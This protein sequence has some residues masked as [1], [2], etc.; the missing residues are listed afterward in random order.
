MSDSSTTL[1]HVLDDPPPFHQKLLEY[2]ARP[3]WSPDGRRIAFVDKSFGDVSE[4]D[5]ETRKVRELTKGLGDHHSFLRVLFLPNGD[6]LLIGPKVFK[7]Y[8][9]S[10]YRES[11]LWIMD[12]DAQFAPRP[13]GLRPFEG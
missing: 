13:L 8:E 12:R 4:I 6:Y 7:D 11:E 5:L 9:A 10:R 3:Y 1:E 2:G